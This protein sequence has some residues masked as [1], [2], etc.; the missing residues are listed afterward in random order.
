MDFA[1]VV[2]FLKNPLFKSPYARICTKWLDLK[3]KIGLWTLKKVEKCWKCFFRNILLDDSRWSWIGPGVFPWPQRMFSYPKTPSE[4]ILKFFE[5]INFWTSKSIFSTLP[6]L[7]LWKVEKTRFWASRFPENIFWI[8]ELG[9]T[10]L[11][12]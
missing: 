12:D 3:P 5:K 2:C 10:K 8:D 1:Y 11:G 7:P 4:V 6:I 9:L